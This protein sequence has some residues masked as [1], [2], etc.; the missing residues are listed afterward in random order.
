MTNKNAHSVLSADRVACF[1]DS[2]KQ[3]SQG[4]LLDLIQGCIKINH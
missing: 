2:I 3:K 4:Q 1:F